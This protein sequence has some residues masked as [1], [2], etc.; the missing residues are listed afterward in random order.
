MSTGPT[1]KPRRHLMT[2]GQPVRSSSTPMTLTAVQRWVMSILAVS[3]VFHMAG[4]VVLAAAF[5]DQRSSQVGLLVIAGAFGLLAM[6]AGLLIHGSKATSPWLLL[7]LVPPA[8]GA[9]W[10]FG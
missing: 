3:T 5:V 7:G 6:T 1:P 10:I 9:W 2:P 8:L 4:G